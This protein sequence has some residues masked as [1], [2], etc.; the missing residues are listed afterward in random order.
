MQK[1][2]IDFLN[3]SQY[4]SQ[5]NPLRRRYLRTNILCYYLCFDAIWDRFLSL[6]NRDGDDA[7][8]D[9]AEPS[10]RSIRKVR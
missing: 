10:L 3:P 6:Y 7:I 5:Y 1:K 2:K 9:S 8:L 4:L